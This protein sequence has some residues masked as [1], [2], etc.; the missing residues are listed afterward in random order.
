MQKFDVRG[1]RTTV[2][3]ANTNVTTMQYDA[4]NRSA[5][6]TDA[7]GGVTV[8]AFDAAGRNTVVVDPNGN[9]TTF[10]Y[11]A[12]DRKTT[13]TDP[14]S[15][16]AT[17]GYDNANQLTDQTDRDGRRTTFAYDSGGRQTGETWVGASPSETVTYTYDNVNAL[18]GVTDANATLTFTYDS[19]GRQITAAT[20]GTAGQP[21]VTLTSGFDQIGNR[22]TL[23]DS[24]SN[25][26][27]TTY[28]YDSALRLVTI[29][30]D[31][32]NKATTVTTSGPRVDYG[33]DNAN[34]LTSESRTIGGAGTAV[35]TSFAYDNAN[36]L[37]TLTHQVTG[38]SALATYVYGY[39]NGNRVT[40]E[41]NAE[42]TVTY[43]YDV[44]NQL[45]GASGSR[46]ETYTY[47]SGG[48]RTM[49]GYTTG[50]GNELTASPGTT[51]TYDNEGNM[52]AQANTSTH[53]VT[54]Y[55][56]DYHNRLTGV[57]VGGSATATYVY[58]G[59]D[60]RIGF[61]DNGTQT[62]V[63][64]DGQNPYADFDGS[65]TLKE[66]YLYGPAIDALLART[67]SSGTTAWYLTD[68][69][70]TVRDIAS[71]AGTVIDHLSYDS[72]GGVLSE[73][74]P[75]N[76]DRFKFTGRELDSAT[77]QYYYR[78]RWYTPV[79][80]RFD[81]Q[82]LIGFQSASTNFYVYV[83]NIPTTYT[84]PTGNHK[85]DKWWEYTARE[86]QKW[87]H[88]YYKPEN[89]GDR[90]ATR[91]ELKDANDDWEKG[92]KPDG[93]GH[94]TEKNPSDSS[95]ESSNNKSVVNY[96]PI[97]LVGVAVGVI[98]ICLVANPITLIGGVIVYI[99]GGY[100]GTCA[101]VATASIVSCM[102]YTCS[103][104]NIT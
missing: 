11:D 2:K 89:I 53:V 103:T 14:L 16:S 13:M 42:G 77:G 5:T 88:R 80:G 60:R 93:E 71:S 59:L 41:Q 94:R 72:F 17:Y 12:A 47:D 26:G 10:G 4:L 85:Q 58:D 50:T 19:G 81:S 76:G 6:M 36:R 66:R 104:S 73:S 40:S 39:D 34:R 38:G 86:F 28:T 37:T 95:K 3:D 70:G 101:I 45:T 56:Y 22:T 68:R 98:A 54:S 31:F 9:R 100:G 64:W 78:A 102:I 82:D 1:N 90:N 79:I 57:T 52:T 97:L 27:R 63:V 23:Y 67:D 8:L 30:R 35:A 55:T 51:Y 43:G 61:K 92:G 7:R 49:T 24:L 44:T 20:S 96:T 65:G 84:D 74:T 48:N 25:T 62:W 15:H 29:A 75:A 69:L 21:S 91:D 33:Y 46:A 83:A 32:F 87:F 99:T 18:T